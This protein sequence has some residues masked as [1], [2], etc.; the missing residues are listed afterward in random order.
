VDEN[1]ILFVRLMRAQSIGDT[2]SLDF[3]R[4]RK[5]FEINP[6]HEI[7]KG[8]NVSVHLLFLGF[9]FTSSPS[10]SRPSK[11][12]YYIRS[13]LIDS[14]LCRYVLT[15]SSENLDK[16]ESINLERREYY[17]ANSISGMGR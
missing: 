6:E 3:M 15:R 13:K 11:P 8:L 17:T 12:M 14:T 1:L 4:S 9:A 10:I 16:V 2:S 7:I 5:V